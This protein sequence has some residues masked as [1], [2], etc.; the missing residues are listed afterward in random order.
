LDLKV[1]V[2]AGS[3]IQ[4][5]YAGGP[6]GL[7][8]RGRERTA[9]CTCGCRA[10]RWNYRRG[11]LACLTAGCSV[12][13]TVGHT[14]TGVYASSSLRR[15]WAV[16]DGEQLPP[17]EGV[18]VSPRSLERKDAILSLTMASASPRLEAA[19]GATRP[20]S[21]PDEIRGNNGTCRNQRGG[22][23]PGGVFQVQGLRPCSSSP[24]AQVGILSMLLVCSTPAQAQDILFQETSAP[25]RE[26]RG[27]S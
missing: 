10:C 19:P 27:G 25:R 26:V 16:E 13:Q 21:R 11:F 1:A 6:G 8:P 9:C 5:P 7:C 24:S 18:N 14:L 20:Q 4:K 12:I 17:W 15:C 2:Q 23:R 22:S 3:L